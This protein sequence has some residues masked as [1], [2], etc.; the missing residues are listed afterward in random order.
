MDTPQA[1]NLGKCCF[2]A[3]AQEGFFYGQNMKKQAQKTAERQEKIQKLLTELGE[4]P[5]IYASSKDWARDV[6]VTVSTIKETMAE[7]SQDLEDLETILK[8]IDIF[9]E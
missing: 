8:W 9:K 4:D 3:A 2:G 7:L 5:V 6:K 1:A